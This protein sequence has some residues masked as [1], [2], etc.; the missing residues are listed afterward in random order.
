PGADDKPFVIAPA[1]WVIAGSRWLKNDR[2][3][4]FIKVS[5]KIPGDDLL[6]SW[7]RAVS[8]DIRGGSD[9]MLLQD[10]INFSNNTNAGRIIDRNLGDPND[11]YME[12]FEYSDMR[13]PEDVAADVKNDRADRNLFRLQLFRVDAHTGK[14]TRTQSGS[15]DTINWYMDGHGHVLARRD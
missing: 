10:T 3:A 8:V 4:V 7:L 1:E 15:Y 11:I 5:K 12:M 6:H 13:S 2:L 9:V 14:H